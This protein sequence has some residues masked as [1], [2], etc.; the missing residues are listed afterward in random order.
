MNKGAAALARLFQK[1]KQ[2]DVAKRIGV[3]ASYLSLLAAGKRVPS[4]KVAAKLEREYGIP[5]DAWVQG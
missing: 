2:Q 1:P 5:V 3:G 4:L